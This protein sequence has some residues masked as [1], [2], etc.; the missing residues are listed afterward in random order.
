VQVLLADALTMRVLGLFPHLGV[1]YSLTLN[2]PGSATWVVSVP[3]WNDLV[4]AGMGVA[5]TWVYIVDEQT[6]DERVEWWGLLWAA[7]ISPQAHTVQLAAAGV[8][9]VLERRTNRADLTYTQQDQAAIARGLVDQ[10]QTGASRNLHIDTSGVGNTGVL[11]DRTYV[12]VERKRFGQLLSDLSAVI[13]GFDYR[14]DAYGSGGGV[15]PTHQLALVYPAPRTSPVLTVVARGNVT[16]AQV[17]IVGTN[18]VSDVDGIGAQDLRVTDHLDVPGYPALDGAVNHTSVVVAATL[19]EAAQRMLQAN[20]APRVTMR[21]TVLVGAGEHL[22]L[23]PGQAVRLLEV[24]TAY[25][26]LMVVTDVSVQNAGAGLTADVSLVEPSTLERTDEA[27]G[28]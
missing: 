8:Q 24:D 7:T 1:H 13:N 9:T 27:T 11:R 4:A 17:A 16:L 19:D 3:A 2:G 23:L 12:G 22:D 15:S 10:A 21:L 5:R 25:D 6:D 20:N 28:P 14:F 26:R 18:I